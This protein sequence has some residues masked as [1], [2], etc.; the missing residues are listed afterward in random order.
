MLSNNLLHPYELTKYFTILDCLQRLGWYQLASVS[1][2]FGI[3][4]IWM[5]CTQA[6]TLLLIEIAHIA[7][8]VPPDEMDMMGILSKFPLQVRFFPISRKK[9]HGGKKFEIVKYFEPKVFIYIFQQYKF[10]SVNKPVSKV[11]VS[12]YYL[13]WKRSYF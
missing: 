10:V 5:F 2:T 3:K 8:T 4:D 11:E 1:T 7:A 6:A 12:L 9:F 13:H